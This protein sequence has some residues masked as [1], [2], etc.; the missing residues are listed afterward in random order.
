M[1]T[2]SEFR[3]DIAEMLAGETS[4]IAYGTM[5]VR[6]RQT[7]IEAHFALADRW[8]VENGQ[9]SEIAAIYGDTVLARR[10]AVAVMPDTLR[11]QF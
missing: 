9:V 1:E 5:V 7:G 2:W 8:V 4:V 6:G 10:A 11:P 3:F